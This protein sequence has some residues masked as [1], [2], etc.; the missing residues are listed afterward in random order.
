VVISVP[1]SDRYIDF[2]R[3]L[4]TDFEP[5]RIR[6]MFGGAG[7]YSGERFFAILVD[8]A[9]YLKVDADNRAQYEQRGLVPFSYE[10][11]AGRKVPMSYYPA[12]PETLEERE[13]LKPWV[14]GALEAA[15]RA[16]R[17]PAAPKGSKAGKFGVTG[18]PTSPEAS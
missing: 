18:P 4:L 1:V 16:S 9:L 15:R 12:P 5:L 11:K 7:V 3:D 8:D 13:A 10:T 2:A 6:R 14:R 17:G